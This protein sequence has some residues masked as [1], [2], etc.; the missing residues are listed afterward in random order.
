[1]NNAVFPR[2]LR[3]FVVEAGWDQSCVKRSAHTQSNNYLHCS[4]LR[5]PF[6]GIWLWW[7]SDIVVTTSKSVWG[8]TGIYLMCFELKRDVTPPY[9][10]ILMHY[11]WSS[12]FFLLAAVE[13]D[14]SFHF[15]FYL[16][17]FEVMFW[18]T[19]V[20]FFVLRTNTNQVNQS[21]R[22]SCVLIGLVFISLHMNWIVE[23]SPFFML[24]I[25][26]FIHFEI[27]TSP[28]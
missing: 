3:L 8:N 4:I 28:Q 23:I 21:L 24:I 6:G 27:A 11:L 17:A 1:M 7:M 25:T 12:F 10:Y 14:F 26:V 19:S 2:L 16:Y 9:S 22:F 5:Y 15:S 13:S 18:L 20:G